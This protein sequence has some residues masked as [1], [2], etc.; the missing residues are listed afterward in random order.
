[1]S[2]Y[3]PV[4]LPYAK[5]E[6]SSFFVRSRTAYRDPE[7]ALEDITPALTK[8]GSILTVPVLIEYL[9]LQSLVVDGKV[10][11]KDIPTEESPEYKGE[12]YHEGYAQIRELQRRYRE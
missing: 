2:E 10:S 5:D 9:V 1:M 7:K 3:I 8:E 11:V 6:S 12:L 4:Y